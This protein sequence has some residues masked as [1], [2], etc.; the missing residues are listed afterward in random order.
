[1]LRIT[2]DTNVLISS[3]LNPCGKPYEVLQLVR[4]SKAV[5]VLSLEILDELK[6]VLKYPKIIKYLEKRDI[7]PKEIDRFL[8]R[9]EGIAKITTT[10]IDIDIIQ[11][12][13]SDNMVLSCAVEGKADFII[14]GDHHL[15]YS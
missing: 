6:R 1:M 8:D 7:D 10:T 13:P 12:D 14:S 9:L 2:V 4:K 5:L 11:D 15:L 3:I